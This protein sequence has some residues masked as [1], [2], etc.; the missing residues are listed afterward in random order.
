MTDDAAAAVGRS[1][2]EIQAGAL[3]ELFSEESGEAVL[4]ALRTASPR[5]SDRASGPDNPARYRQ[6]GRIRHIHRTG[7]RGQ[8]LD[9]VYPGRPACWKTTAPLAKESFLDAVSSRLGLSG[10]DDMRLFMIDFGGFAGI[11]H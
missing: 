7:R 11:R 8:V 2:G 3:F 6:G 9:P 4:K 5:R 1:G 10:G